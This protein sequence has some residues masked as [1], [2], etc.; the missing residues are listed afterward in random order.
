MIPRGMHFCPILSE[1]VFSHL[2]VGSPL[3]RQPVLK[4]TVAAKKLPVHDP[5]WCA[6]LLHPVGNRFFMAFCRI[7]FGPT[8]GFEK[9]G[10]CKEAAGARSLLV[11]FFAPSGENLLLP[12][13]LPYRL[14]ADMAGHWF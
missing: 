9:T 1:V 8:T 3:G 12:N 11:S 10:G 14:G 13:F 6:F 2:F 4:K 5:S 7:A